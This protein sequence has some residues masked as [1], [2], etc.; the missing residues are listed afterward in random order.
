VDLPLC[1]LACGND[2]EQFHYWHRATLD[3]ISERRAE[4]R[5]ETWRGGGKVVVR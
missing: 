4:L 3:R 2:R 5:R 1:K